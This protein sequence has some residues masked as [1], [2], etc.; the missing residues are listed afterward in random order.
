[1]THSQMISGLNTDWGILEFLPGLS[2]NNNTWCEDIHDI[3]WRGISWC[4]IWSIKIW[5][6]LNRETNEVYSLQFYITVVVAAVVVVVI[7]KK[8]LVVPLLTVMTHRS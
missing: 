1:M 5:S 2:L 6:T 4:N 3:L 7:V 8:K